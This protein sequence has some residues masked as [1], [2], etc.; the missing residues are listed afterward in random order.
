MFAVEPSPAELD[1]LC[2]ELFNG[3]GGLRWPL[4]DVSILPLRF[5]RLSVVVPGMGIGSR[6][7]KLIL[8][9]VGAPRQ[10]LPGMSG[11]AIE[12]RAAD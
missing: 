12:G 11:R 1:S 4:K 5:I 10:T 2:D 9:R 3:A 7:D 6:P 8:E